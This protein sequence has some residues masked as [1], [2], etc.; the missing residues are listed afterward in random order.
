M[1]PRAT[2]GETEEGIQAQDENEAKSD[3]PVALRKM[4]EMPDGEAENEQQQKRGAPGIKRAGGEQVMRGRREKRGENEDQ[5]RGVKAGKIAIGQQARVQE[6]HRGRD[7]LVL[8]MIQIAR[9][10]AHEEQK[11]NR[12]KTSRT[13]SH[14]SPSTRDEDIFPYLD[15]GD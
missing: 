2:G 12:K 7:E 13:H 10:R 5:I 15:L 1:I 14:P 8:V 9:E 11:Q 3:E 6:E 4:A